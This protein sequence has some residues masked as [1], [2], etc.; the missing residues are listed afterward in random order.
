MKAKPTDDLL[1]PIFDSRE[2]EQKYAKLREK[3]NLLE[4]DRIQLMKKIFNRI[5]SFITRDDPPS[6]SELLLLM[7][8]INQYG[9][10]DPD[11]KTVSTTNLT[12]V[13]TKMYSF[14]PT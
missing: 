7:G 3:I 11:S 8:E 1:L 9:K 5:M 10:D 4:D 6:I 13:M 14:G 2:E 12:E